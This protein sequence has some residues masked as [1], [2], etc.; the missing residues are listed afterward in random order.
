MLDF[1]YVIICPHYPDG[2]DWVEASFRSVRGVIRSSWK[3]EGGK[4][5]LNVTIP[6]NT[7]ATVYADKVYKVEG[8]GEEMN[9]VIAEK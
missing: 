7:K 5:L 2:L 6:I 8:T 9:F 4:I 3:R 1:R